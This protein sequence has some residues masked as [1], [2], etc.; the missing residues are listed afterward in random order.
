VSAS[1]KRGFWNIPNTLTVLRIA[2]VPVMVWLLYDP[3]SRSQDFIAFLVFVVAMITDI[4]DG[5]LARKWNLTSTI[6][7]YLD[8][9]ADKLMVITVL[10]MLIPLGRVPAWI[11]ALLLCRELAVTGLRSIASQE[12]ILLTASSLGKLK[13]SFQSTAIGFLL[14]H[15]QPWIPIDAV[16]AGNVLLY[17]A[18]ACSV[19]SGLE[20]FVSF[21]KGSKTTA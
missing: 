9:L 4:I 5:W 15:W 19:A 14:W 6:G 7:A 1:T 18:T 16:S 17:I 3:P 13:T 21:M 20:Y 8:P 11:V 12:G 10:V 2:A